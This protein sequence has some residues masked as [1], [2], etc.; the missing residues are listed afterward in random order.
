MEKFFEDYTA[1]E[2]IDAVGKIKRLEIRRK[3][4]KILKEKLEKQNWESQ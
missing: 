1:D 4:F 2:V 3:E